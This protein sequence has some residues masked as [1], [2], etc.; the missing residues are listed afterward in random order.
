MTTET[1]TFKAKFSYGLSDFGFSIA[2]TIPA[3]FLMI[4]L[5]DV[6]GIPPALVGT[7]LLVAKI[8]DAVIDPFIGHLSDRLQ[9]RWGRRRPFLL[10]FAVPFGLSFYLL[11]LVPSTPSL[12]WQS[13]I[14]LGVVIFFITNFSLLSVPYS[15]LAPEMTRDYNE[16][17][18]LNA[19][20][21]FFSIIGGLVAVLLPA[22]FLSL[23]EDLRYGYRVMG[24][25]LGAFITLLP[26]AAFF[27]TKE[28]QLTG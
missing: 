28:K 8:W 16:R 1:L 17:T 18:R 14:V 25:S 7:V 6:A 21:M 10:W 12:F 27:G 11:W 9:T 19:Y 5:T 22:Y 2:Y 3:F 15:S 24:L 26:L 23:S 13:L 4:F 20:R